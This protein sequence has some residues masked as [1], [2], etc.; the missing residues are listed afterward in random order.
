[1]IIYNHVRINSIIT[2]N[3]ASKTHNTKSHVDQKI[4]KEAALKL[5]IISYTSEVYSLA[6]AKPAGA[7]SSCIYK[8]GHT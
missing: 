8:H 3:N 4:L 5:G 6:M 7:F 1:M 2:K